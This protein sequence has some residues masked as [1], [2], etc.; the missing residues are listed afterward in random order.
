MADPIEG[1]VICVYEGFGL[2][3]L[4]GHEWWLWQAKSGYYILCASG[5]EY[6]S[7]ALVLGER[8]DSAG[9]VCS[10]RSWTGRSDV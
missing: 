3:S 1:S 4:G 8:Y 2:C 10:A 9:E 5:R 7:S 6:D